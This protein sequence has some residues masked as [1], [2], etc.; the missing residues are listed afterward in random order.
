M[1]NDLSLCTSSS[2]GQ[3]QHAKHYPPYIT[4]QKAVLEKEGLTFTFALAC[5]AAHA[6]PK[7]G[8]SEEP[9]YEIWFERVS[10]SKCQN[11]DLV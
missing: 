11:D 4:Q 2:I 5:A 8:S 9:A 3:R 1:M 7:S 10:P 6:G